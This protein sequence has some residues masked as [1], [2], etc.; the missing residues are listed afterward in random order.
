[1]ITNRQV[2]TVE[3]KLES[4]KNDIE[5]FP[6]LKIKTYKKGEYIYYEGDRPFHAYI[7]LT[8]M[9][10]TGKFSE[11]GKEI[12]SSVYYKNKIFGETDLLLKEPRKYY[13]QAIEDNTTLQLASFE[14]LFDTSFDGEKKT[15]PL[16]HLIIS[17]ISS[18]E[19]N[20]EILKN[21]RAEIKVIHFIY[22]MAIQQGIKIGCFEIMV[23]NPLRHKDIAYILGITRQTVTKI[24]NQLKKGNLIYFDNRKILIRDMKKLKSLIS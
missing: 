16:M 12:V 23:K 21:T 2:D 20:I 7:V 18:L 10:K 19:K 22:N 5:S 13:A 14:N 6:G 1:M 8:G 11:N 4:L 9:V 17:K 24:L 15:H 3:L